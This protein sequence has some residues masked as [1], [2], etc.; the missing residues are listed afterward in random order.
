LGLLA[1]ILIPVLLLYAIVLPHLAGGGPAYG[2]RIFSNLKQIE[3]AKQLWA[4]DHSATGA[5]LITV[6]DL[7]PYLRIPSSQYSNFVPPVICER[8]IINPLG[9]S[10]EAELTQSCK[11]WPKGTVFQLNPMRM[12]PPNTLKPAATVPSVSTKP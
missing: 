1:A 6:R 5:V 8:Y 9:V 7:T 12:I 2:A 4:E 10:P 11:S 3:L